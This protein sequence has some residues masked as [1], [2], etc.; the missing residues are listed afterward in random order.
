MS[1]YTDTII[2]EANRVQSSQYSDGK[3]SS[4]WT[5]GVSD[6]IKLNVGDKLS[7]DS[8]FISDLGAEDST[9]EF[10]GIKIQDQQVFKT[11]KVVNVEPTGF[12]SDAFKL[13]LNGTPSPYVYSDINTETIV[14]KNIK[15]NEVNVLLSFYKSN[16]GEF[17]LNLP[18]YHHPAT[19]SE[20][21]Q[22]WVKVR[23]NK[24]HLQ[25]GGEPTTAGSGMALMCSASHIFNGDMVIDEDKEYQGL[26][27]DNS[28]YMIFG[29]RRTEIN[30]DTINTHEDLPRQYRDLNGYMNYKIAIKDL[31]KMEVPVGFN[32]P[33]EISSVISGQLQKNTKLK[34]KSIDILNPTLDTIISNN[35]GPINE[36][37]TNKLF[38][39]GTYNGLTYSTAVK[40][41]GGGSEYTPIVLPSNHGQE[42]RD[43]QSSFQY[44]GIKRPELYESGINLKIRVNNQSRQNGNVILGT[45][46]LIIPPQNNIF[47]TDGDVKNYLKI[48]PGSLQNQIPLFGPHDVVPEEGRYPNWLV[49]STPSDDS[50]MRDNLNPYFT[51]FLQENP[52]G[53]WNEPN[54]PVY[55][56]AIAYSLDISP[57]V[58]S[59]IIQIR[60]DATHPP[61]V[62]NNWNK[63]GLTCS[64]FPFIPIDVFLVSIV[65]QTSTYQ[66]IKISGKTHPTTVMP[67]LTEVDITI[68]VGDDFQA[69][70]VP[71]PTN[72]T[73]LNTGME[74][75][76]SNL[77]AL[78]GFFKEQERYPE[79]FN[80]NGENCQSSYR[81]NVDSHKTI[82]NGEDISV[83]THRYLHM[84][85]KYNKDMPKELGV[86][87]G[88]VEDPT[89][90]TEL[91]NNPLAGEPGVFTSFGYDNIPSIFS[92][93][94]P[95]HNTVNTINEDFSSLPVFVKYFK[96]NENNG[97]GMS[98]SQ[99]DATSWNNGKNV[100]YRPNVESENNTGDGMWGGFAYKTPSTCCIV[101][102]FQVGV[103]PSRDWAQLV[104]QETNPSQVIECVKSYNPSGLMSEVAANCWQNNN[105]SATNALKKHHLC[106][107]ILFM[108]NTKKLFGRRTNKY[109]N[110]Q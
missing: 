75:T 18:F 66:I 93:N 30:W 12:G 46:H 108:S 99:F 58:D 24:T 105:G 65:S 32:S 57:D 107:N 5:N 47:N 79:L 38:N 87:K 104:G 61:L 4:I 98:K 15:D 106:Y 11:S 31:L 21:T 26:I 74:W 52:F 59:D 43:Y 89:E 70:D 16:N 63:T 71:F 2:L 77:E 48:P 23:K 3:D 19:P 33:S 62:I 80:M 60:I 67:A 25:I 37:P 95:A 109:K 81:K 85:S 51:D 41:Y 45:D 101:P 7:L 49:D 91:Q 68:N 86:N 53:N 50:F 8:A 55:S 1:G 9:I 69:S 44:I 76:Q 102:K 22:A 14:L 88:K 10:K 78:Q 36:T 94:G 28:R 40:F 84:N 83:D 96:E 39:C 17:M 20:T 110:K 97:S 64:T 92:H 54:V 82:Y 34:N 35:I 72:Y 73:V 27:I 90:I 13:I 100:K 42:V 103:R 56:G 6:G 29:Q